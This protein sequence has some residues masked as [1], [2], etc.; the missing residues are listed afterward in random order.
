LGGPVANL[1][2]TPGLTEQGLAGG[3]LSAERG[4]SHVYDGGITQTGDAT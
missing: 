2:N 3:N 4:L 1:E